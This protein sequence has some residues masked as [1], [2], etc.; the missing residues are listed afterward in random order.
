MPFSIAGRKHRRGPSTAP[1]NAE[2]GAPVSAHPLT[3]VRVS[4]ASAAVPRSLGRRDTELAFDRVFVPSLVLDHTELVLRQAGIQGHEGFAV[5]AGT[6]A[7]GDAHVATVLV[8]RATTEAWHR[9]ITPETTARVLTALDERDLVP[10]VQLHSHPRQAFLSDTDAIR[11]LVAVPGFVSVVIP[12]FGFADLA[13]VE[14]WS[15]HEYAGR[16]QWRELHRGERARRFII[17][18]SVIRVE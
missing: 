2:P 15:A 12:D 9:E 18:D 5:W 14:L 16:G 17:D 13:D 8:P 10:V 11:P 6:L 7:G 3:A 1:I 4:A